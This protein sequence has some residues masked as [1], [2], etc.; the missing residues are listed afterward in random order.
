MNTQQPP[1]IT[2][3]LNEFLSSTSL[4]D[5]EQQ[6]QGKVLYLEADPV[7]FNA[8]GNEIIARRPFETI[9]NPAAL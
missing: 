1:S 3:G 6:L 4:R 8:P 7:H 9:T 2:P 5:W